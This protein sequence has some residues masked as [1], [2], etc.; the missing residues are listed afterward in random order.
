MHVK[1]IRDTNHVI[2]EKLYKKTNQFNMSQ[3]NNILTQDVISVYFEIYRPNGEILGICSA[4]SYIIDDNMI[5]VK[6]W[7]ISCRF[8]EIGLEDLIL[9]YLVE[10]ANGKRVMFKYNKTEYNSKATYMIVS[11]EEFK[12]VGENTYIEYSYSQSTKDKLRLKTNL[13][14]IHDDK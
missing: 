12:S 3:Q 5:T 10:K 4:I 14:I 11:N 8:F 6:N 2:A 1:A 9:M 13:E 7:A